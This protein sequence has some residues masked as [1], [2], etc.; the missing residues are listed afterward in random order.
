MLLFRVAAFADHYRWSPPPMFSIG[1]TL[2]LIGVFIHQTFKQSVEGGAILNIPHFCRFVT[3]VL[4]FSHLYTCIFTLFTCT[5][6]Y[7]QAPT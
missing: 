3:F 2:V 5:R 7:S 4:M 6:L 1:L